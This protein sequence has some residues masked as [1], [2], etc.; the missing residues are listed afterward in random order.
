V[1]FGLFVLFFYTTVMK[2]PAAL[3]GVGLAAGLIWDAVIDPYIGY[4]SDNH[5]GPLGRRHGFMLVGALLM[6]VT[7]C[8]LLSPPS[9]LG[10]AALFAWL[11]GTTLAFR[12]TSALFRIPYLSLGAEMSRDYHR[13]TII[14]GVRAFFGLCGMLAA[15]V[16]SFSLFF[17]NVAD[18]VDPKLA[19][20]SYPRMGLVFGV[21]MTVAAL[22]CIGG[23]WSHRHHTPPPGLGVS[24]RAGFVCSFASAW[25]NRPFRRVGLGFTLFFLAV[26]LNASLAIH[27]FTWYV[28]I[29]ASDALSRIQLCF[30]LGALGGVVVWVRFAR[31]AEK[32]TLCLGSIVA[33][34]AM[35]MLAT[36]LFGE[37]RVFGTGNSLPLLAGNL[38]AGGFAGAVWVLPGS[39]L[40]VV[41]DQDELQTGRRREGLFF[42]LT[43]F[44]EKVASGA[45]F[46]VAGVLLDLFVGLVPGSAPD[47]VA[48]ARIGL[49]Y[50]ALPGVVLLGAAV[51]IGGYPLDRS[52]VAAIQDALQ[53]RRSEPSPA[54]ANEVVRL[55]ARVPVGG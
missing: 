11:L 30:F 13:R 45:A 37:G 46:L 10:T 3:V 22:V 19:Y 54:P 39:M 28:Q 24:G 50:G 44:G 15:A 48:S 27:Y 2:L 1:L 52:A 41:A 16:L 38:L 6:G 42:G 29:P 4:R 55:V 18:G 7:F 33:T 5:R 31:C 8:A 43:N 17:P 20:D 25:Q 53:R 34:S 40:A 23:T 12:F 21:L 9:G 47:A 49:L 14:S 51:S 26:V 35:M 36:L 32:R